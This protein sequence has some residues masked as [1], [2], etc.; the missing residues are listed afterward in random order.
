MASLIDLLSNTFWRGYVQLGLLKLIPPSSFNFRTNRDTSPT[1]HIVGFPQTHTKL[2]ASTLL[3][4]T[5][6][7]F[8]RIK[9]GDIEVG[10]TIFFTKII[11]S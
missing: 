6:V 1:L 2:F 7:M 5:A 3:V 4:Q 8:K 9:N 10:Y 11:T